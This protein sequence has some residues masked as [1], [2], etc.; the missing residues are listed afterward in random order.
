MP[1]TITPI[2][3]RSLNASEFQ[4]NSRAKFGFSPTAR[5]PKRLRRANLG[6]TFIIVNNLLQIAPGVFEN[7]ERRQS[8]GGTAPENGGGQ[9]RPKG[10]PRRHPAPPGDA[11]AAPRPA[12]AQKQDAPILGARI[13]A[14]PAPTSNAAAKESIF[15]MPRRS[16]PSAPVSPPPPPPPPPPIGGTKD[17]AFVP[18]SRAYCCAPTF[19]NPRLVPIPPFSPDARPVPSPRTM[20]IFQRP[21]PCF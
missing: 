14:S 17:A 8:L 1:K 10:T 9:P 7:P 6:I 2:A 19:N 15:L 13:R 20:K 11:P 16:F 21:R 3:P 12:C 18:P 4:A 5:P